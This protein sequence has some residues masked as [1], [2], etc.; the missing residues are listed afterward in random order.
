VNESARSVIESTFEASNKGAI[1]FGQVIEALSRIGVESYQ[2]DYRSCRSSYILP[3]DET[4]DLAFGR[5]EHA[6]ADDFDAE[7]VRAAIRGAQQ[8]KVMYPEFKHLTQAAGCIGYTVWIAG[9]HVVY[10]GR[11]GETHVER[12]PD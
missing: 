9:R 12:F 3:G 1:H 2:V 8:G 10:Y 4:V 5:A 11:K 7:A 6:I